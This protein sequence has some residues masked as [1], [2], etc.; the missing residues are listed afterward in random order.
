[1][2]QSHFRALIRQPCF[3]SP[4]SPRCFQILVPLFPSP[5]FL[6]SQ[7]C[8]CV[9]RRM[10]LW[11]SPTPAPLAPLQFLCQLQP[12]HSLLCLQSWWGG[13][14]ELLGLIHCHSKSSEAP[15]CWWVCQVCQVCLGR[16]AG[17]PVFPCGLTFSGAQASPETAFQWKVNKARVCSSGHTCSIWEGNLANQRE[18][19]DS[20]NS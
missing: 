6:L 4:Q 13:C 17:R 19:S 15:N 8:L 16:V 14:P 18:N 12:D 1:M 3:H 11:C 2:V 9:R 7:P 5:L 20:G 10:L